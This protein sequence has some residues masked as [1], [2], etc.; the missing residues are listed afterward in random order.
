MGFCSIGGKFL[1]MAT[2]NI[3]M[4]KNATMMVHNPATFAYG[5]A[6][7]EKDADMLDKVERND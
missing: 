4:P 6:D 7:A 1:I 3:Y 5:N 2:D